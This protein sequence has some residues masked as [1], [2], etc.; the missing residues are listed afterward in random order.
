MGWFYGLIENASKVELATLFG[1]YA[2]LALAFWLLWIRLFQGILFLVKKSK[3]RRERRLQATRR[4]QYTLPDERNE[5]LKSR[6]HTALRTEEPQRYADKENVGV[7]LRYAKKMLSLLKESPLSPVERL[8]V[9][10]LDGVIAAYRGREKWS[11]EDVKA[12]NEIFARL[13]KLSAKYEIAV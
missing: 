10:E 7:R 9:E 4:L 2:C 11:S 1:V 8:D 12:V 6:L 13:L 3:E 5:Y